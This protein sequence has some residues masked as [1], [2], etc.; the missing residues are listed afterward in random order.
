MATRPT[1][2]RVREAMFN[3]LGPPPGGARVLDLFA[4]AGALG[5]EALSRGVER[6]VFVDKDGDAVRTTADNARELGLT[7][8]A[9]VLRLEAHKALAKLADAGERFTWVFIDPPYRSGEAARILSALGAP[10]GP[11]L[12]DDA[13]VIVEHDRRLA[14]DDHYGAIARADRRRYGDTEVSFYRRPGAAA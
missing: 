9:Q 3:I 11:L 10:P 2:D 6:A 8:R 13:V 12:D 1:S 5:L 4:G 14:P 7:D